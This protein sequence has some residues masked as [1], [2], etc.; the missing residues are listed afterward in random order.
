MTHH[1]QEWVIESTANPYPFVRL[2]VYFIMEY[3]IFIGGVYL[4]NINILTA[5]ADYRPQFVINF[6]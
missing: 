4:E 3:P 6:E 1:E 2:E 5:P